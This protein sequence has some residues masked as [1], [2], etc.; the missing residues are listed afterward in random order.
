MRPARNRR[1]RS[2][3]RSELEESLALQLRASGITGHEREYR[4]AALHVGLGPGVKGRL[5][6]AGLGDWRFDFA[7]PEVMF[8]VEV[9]GGGWV[10]GGHNRGVG[11]ARDMQ[12]YHHAADM[13]WFVY[14][15]DAALIASGMACRFIESRTI[16]GRG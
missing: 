13:G 11:F 6:A 10:Q 16:N 2:S 12:K 4:F 8:A 3:N 15:C 5:A 9:E 7:W 14:R 1:R